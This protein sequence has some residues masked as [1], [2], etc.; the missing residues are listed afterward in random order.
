[1][2]SYTFRNKCKSSEKEL[3]KI[4][5]TYIDQQIKADHIEDNN[6]VDSNELHNTIVPCLRCF[7]YY[8]NENDLIEHTKHE[9]N[10][11]INLNVCCYC[12][13]EYDNYKT[14]WDHVECDHLE[15]HLFECGYCIYQCSAIKEMF[16]HLFCSHSNGMSID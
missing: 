2:A 5:E 1:M 8:F 13:V 7:R 9:H 6:V 10:D 16:N 15:D 11:V 14:L 4:T 3:L 12:F